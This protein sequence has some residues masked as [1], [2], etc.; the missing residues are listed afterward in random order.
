M[1]GQGLRRETLLQF[2][3]SPLTLTDF[4]DTFAFRRALREQDRLVRTVAVTAQDKRVENAHSGDID[5]S[6]VIDAA[7]DDPFPFRR[8][9]LGES[10]REVGELVTAA[11]GPNPEKFVPRRRKTEIDAVLPF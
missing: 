5:N 2:L 4:I 3:V 1:V 11:V 6:R 8:P 10:E 7:S 9:D